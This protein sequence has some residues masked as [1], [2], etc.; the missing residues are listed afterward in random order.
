MISNFTDISLEDLSHIA[1]I[2]AS[3]SRMG[4][5]YLLRGDLG[6][7]KTTFAQYFLKSLGCEE[8]VTSPTFNLLQLYELPELQVV[9]MDLY[10]LENPSDIE[11]LGVHELFHQAICLVE[12]PDRLGEE[13]LPEQAINLRWTHNVDS[14]RDLQIITSEETDWDKKRNEAF[15]NLFH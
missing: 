2:C 12:W 13:N 9:H 4:D 5:T 7:G 10:R 11:E 14:S 15:K 3:W 6:T 8:E 1:K